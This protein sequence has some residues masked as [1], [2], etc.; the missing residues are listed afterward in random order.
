VGSVGFC[1]GGRASWIA[2]TTLPLRVAVSFYGGGIA[3]ALID[4]AQNAQGRLLFFWAGR[5]KNILPEHHRALVDALRAAD[6][7]YVS[8]EFGVAEHA[9]FCDARPS[10]HPTA[11][12]E[13]WA[14]T[15]AFLKDALE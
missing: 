5:D 1:M 10:Y 12:A 15:L 6:K 14:L 2:S 13:A 9:F 7:A 4:R 8:V 3:P 11:A